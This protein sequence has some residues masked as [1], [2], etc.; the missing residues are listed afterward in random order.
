MTVISATREAE[1]G[2]IVVP[3]QFREKVSETPHV[4][5]TSWRCGTHSNPSYV[6]GI[7]RRIMN[8]S[9]PGKK[10]KTLSEK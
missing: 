9:G 4:N 2:R 1:I 5:K 8:E 3:G 10:Q 7:G 6:E